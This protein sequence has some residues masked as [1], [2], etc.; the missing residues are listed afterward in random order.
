[1]PVDLST[2]YLGLELSSPIVV[3]AC[4]LTG[5]VDTL[6]SLQ[7]AGAAAVVLPSLFEEQIR[8][9]ELELAR[10]Q[11]R[12]T[13]MSAESLSYFPEL[14]TYNSGPDKYLELIRSAKSVMTIPIIASLNGSSRG[15]WL[16]YASLMEKAGADA[17]ELNIY[18]IPIDSS[19]RSEAV[20]LHYCELVSELKKELSIP[21]AVKIGPY[22]SSIPSFAKKVFEAGANGLVLFNRFL[23][24]DVNL[25]TLE[26]VPALELS[27][28]SELRIALRWIAILRDQ[29]S[30]S[31][32]A[33]GGVHQVEDVVKA[34][35]VGADVTMLA[36]AL[37]RNG[38]DHIRCVKSEL[39]AWL[40]DHEYQSVQQLRG[41]MSFDRCINPYGL[42][43]ANYMR[44]L[45]S[46]S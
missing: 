31:L 7:A 9:T 45:I 20:E 27:H 11:D 23:A 4:P 22:F 43:R 13:D 38:V 34:L 18:T 33:T 24:P 40:E 39:I 8:H 21:L 41:S 15:G 35:L 2:R 30:A 36:S 46:Y 14:E 26:F 12:Q 6:V 3:S 37:L 44:A 1:M 17:L 19:Q 32:A 29:I 42:L 16:H 28:S 25:A 10:L 5:D